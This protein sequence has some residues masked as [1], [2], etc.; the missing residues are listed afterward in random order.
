M[1]TLIARRYADLV[2]LREGAEDPTD[3]EW[4]EFL[5]ILASGEGVHGMRVLGV[6]DGGGP[7]GEQ[8]IRLRNALG[9]SNVKAA[10]VSDSVK[11]R[12]VVSSIAFITSK[13]KSFAKRDL[14]AAYEYLELDESQR[15]IAEKVISELSGLI[16]SGRRSTADGQRPS[17]TP[18]TRTHREKW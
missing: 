12:F 9:D 18:P 17:R 8:R 15:R 11:V 2:I 4:D 6:T 16:G 7:S 3:D 13:I 5:R 1:P 10:I 14:D